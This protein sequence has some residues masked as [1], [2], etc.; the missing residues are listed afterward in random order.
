M[1]R[2]FLPDYTRALDAV[3][4]DRAR[5]E[6]ET[7][8]RDALAQL[9]ADVLPYSHAREAFNSEHRRT[10]IA[11][12]HLKSSPRISADVDD[13][14]THVDMQLSHLTPAQAEAVARLLAPDL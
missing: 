8:A 12:N 10:V 14:G 7:Q 13:D 2:R 3:A 11:H 5:Y 4:A 1:R 9:L 6:Q